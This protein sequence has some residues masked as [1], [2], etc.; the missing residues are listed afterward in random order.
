MNLQI[1]S[2]V[3]SWPKRKEQMMICDEEILICQCVEVVR[4]TK[5]RLTEPKGKNFD[6]HIQHIVN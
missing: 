6:S 3:K 5:I 4:K 1:Q 2:Y